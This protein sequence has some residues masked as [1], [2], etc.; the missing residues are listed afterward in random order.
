MRITW[1]NV[2]YSKNMTRNILMRKFGEICDILYWTA[3]F[4]SNQ[5]ILS[6]NKRS[7]NSLNFANDLV[8]STPDVTVIGPIVYCVKSA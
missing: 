5:G 4:V 2:T 6:T 7:H 1:G 8:V 3:R